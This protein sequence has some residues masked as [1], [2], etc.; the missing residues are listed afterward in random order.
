MKTLLLTLIT[1]LTILLF[2]CL[3]LK[4]NEYYVRMTGRVEIVHT[5]IPDTVDNLSVAE[6]RAS[7][8]ATDACWSNLNFILVKESDFE[9][10]LQAF[11]IY[12]SYG[13]C[14]SATIGYDTVI[15]LQPT[16]SGLYQFYIYKGPGDVEIDT[17]IV[18]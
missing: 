6:I 14:P 12:E 4:K 15:T 17:M 10:S 13:N 9:Y 1:I 16:L 18:R 7:A 2:S 3:K 8:R 11:G 5:E